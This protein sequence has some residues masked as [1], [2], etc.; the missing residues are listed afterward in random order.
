MTMMK[1]K[2]VLSKALLL[3]ILLIAVNLGFMT[4]TKKVEAATAK[5][6][7]ITT[8]TKPVKNQYVKNKNYNAK[9]KHYYML[10]SYMELLEKQGGGTLVLKKGVYK[11]TNTLY[12][13]SNVTIKLSKGTVLQKLS[14]TGTKTLKA[15]NTLFYLLPSSKQNK[16]NAASGYKSAKNI[17]FIGEKGATIDMGGSSASAIYMSHNNNILVQGITFKNVKGSTYIITING[18]KKVTINNCSLSGQKS[19]TTGILFDIPAKAKKQTRTWVKQDDTVNQNIKITKCNFSSLYRAI[20]SVRFVKD[21]FSSKVVVSDNQF[22]NMGEDVIRAINWDAPVIQNN[23]FTTAGTGAKIIKGM[24]SFA[25][26]I[27]FGGVKNPTVKGNKFK[28]I[29]QPILIY[30]YENPDSELKKTNKRTKNTVTSA[31][32]TM[33]YKENSCTS[34]V[35]PFVRY[36]NNSKTKNYK[37]YFF[38]A[39][40]K[41]YTVTPDTLPYKLNLFFLLC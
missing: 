28:A 34:S 12:V 38:E 29:P 1:K 18:C 2:N 17:S 27:Y 22:K 8:K 36:T 19:K 33:M 11:I 25:K 7:T 24:T 16:K 39:A 40:N 4:P 6:Y 13:P 26:G 9:T 10:R 14:S 32:L 3:G 37:Y 41:T 30:P 21:K 23:T 35:A 5:T 15:T 20:A 31:Q